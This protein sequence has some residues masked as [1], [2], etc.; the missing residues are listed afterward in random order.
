MCNRRSAAV[1]DVPAARETTNCLIA[2]WARAIMSPVRD[3]VSR[4]APKVFSRNS[5]TAH[6]CGIGSPGVLTSQKMETTME[7]SPFGTWTSPISAAAAAAGERA[8][9]WVDFVGEEVWWAELRPEESGRTA[10]VRCAA[11]GSVSDVVGREWNVRSRVIEYGGRPWLPLGRDAAAG[12]V[13]THGEDQRVYRALPGGA[14]APISPE[15]ER[16]AGTRYCDF[17]RVG[18]EVWCLRERATGPLPTDVRRELVALP[19]E[20]DAAGDPEAVRPLAA[21]HHFMTGPKVSPDG[22]HACWLGWD[23]PRMPWDGTDLMCAD[24]RPDGTFGEPR[25]V[26]GGAGIAT[27]QVEWDSLRPG[28]LHVLSDPDGWWNLYE[29]DLSGERRPLCPRAEEFGEPLSRIGARW[30]FPA[31][32]GRLFV[33]HGTAGRRL[34]VLKPDG[35]LTDIDA[36]GRYRDC[37]E[38]VVLAADGHRI[39]A[40]AAGPRQRRSLLLI[41]TER[42][43][44]A[45]RVLRPASTAYAGY[46]SP[47]RHEVFRNAKGDEVHAYVYPPHNPEFAA[48]EG[49]L[50]PY[51]VHVHGGPTTRSQFAADLSLAYFTSRGIGVVDV[52]Y[53]GSTGFGRAYRERLRE[54]WG[55]VDVQDCATAIHGLIERGLADPERVGIRGRSAGGWTAAASLAAEP[56]LYRVAGIYYPLLDPER[57]VGGGTH[58]FESRYLDSLIGPWPAAAARYTAVS[59]LRSADRIRA[60]FVLFQGLRDAICLPELADGFLKRVGREVPHAYLTFE[61]EGHGFRRAETIVACLEAELSAYARGFGFDA[62]GVP[63]IALTV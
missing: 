48:P 44:S 6:T 12:F 18:D 50:P 14:P 32:D 16:P 3:T 37:T 13:F 36:G 42:E 2:A 58:D 63:L 59:P 51:L 62:P 15:P 34:A 30:F 26:F 19:L 24:I 60:P 28:V 43:A 39:V 9:D 45:A 57:W 53:G 35:T 54:N 52:Q 10:L 5:P 33:T 25:K 47:G 4:A 41:D 40:G 46:L 56:G 31:E 49:E 20:G 38:W 55:V 8:V 23:H 17:V 29:V 22:R 27:G 11:D 21:S 7:C 61:D 1:A